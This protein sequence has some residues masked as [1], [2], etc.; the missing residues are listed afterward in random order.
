MPVRRKE[1]RVQCVEYV[2][3]VKMEKIPRMNKEAL[4]TIVCIVV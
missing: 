4:D 2:F 3:L 1:K